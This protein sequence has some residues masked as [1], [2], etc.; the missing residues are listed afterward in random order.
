MGEVGGDRVL[1]NRKGIPGQRFGGV[2]R[3]ETGNVK[4]SGDG[5]GKGL[6]SKDVGRTGWMEGPGE[7]RGREG[8]DRYGEQD[9]GGG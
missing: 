3:E 2:G 7:R 6:E 9:L 5:R 1:G 4:K 8:T